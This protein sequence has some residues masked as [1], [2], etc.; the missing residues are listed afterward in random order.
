M[1]RNTYFFDRPI[2]YL[3]VYPYPDADI[4]HGSIQDVLIEKP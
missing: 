1:I 4:G 3:P 2:A